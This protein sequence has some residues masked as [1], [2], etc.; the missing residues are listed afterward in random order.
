LESGTIYEKYVGD[1]IKNWDSNLEVKFSK[2]LK[3]GANYLALNNMYLD[4]T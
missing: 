4:I 1:C 2:I 3:G